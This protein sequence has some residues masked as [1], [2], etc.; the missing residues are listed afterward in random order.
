MS[1]KDVVH[2]G[3]LAHL[4]KGLV[5]LKKKR[6]KYFL[7]VASAAV[8]LFAVNAILEIVARVQESEYLVSRLTALEMETRDTGAVFDPRTK[9][10]VVRDLRSAGHDIYPSLYTHDILENQ[11]FEEKVSGRILVPLGFK[12][13]TAFVFCNELGRHSIWKSDRY[14][15]YNEDEAYWGASKSSERTAV[16]IGDSMVAGACVEQGEDIASR[17]RE[18]NIRAISLGIPGAGPIR[19]LA[20]FREYALPLQP[21]V[22]VWFFSE[23]ND[24]VDA[25]TESRD[26]FLRQYLKP[27]FRQDLLEKQTDI[28]RTWGEFLV[29]RMQEQEPPE[30]SAGKNFQDMLRR[31]M[32]Y[33]TL[34]Q[35]RSRLALTRGAFRDA[36][37]VELVRNI[38][39]EVKAISED[40]NIDLVLAYLP[41]REAFISKDL[42]THGHIR[43]IASS[44]NIPFISIREVFLSEG[45]PLRFFPRP[46]IFPHYRPEGYQVVAEAVV[47]HLGK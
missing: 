22:I 37:A 12:S 5:Y 40:H 30:R 1:A 45:D 16:L 18:Q 26:P 7:A 21:D 17:L 8:S 32:P 31:L 39:K 43:D 10:V 13:R 15:F 44:L 9:M 47:R 33:T 35:V 38:L 42:S 4:I 19:E 25:I 36:E 29:A 41:R 3:G 27:T 2:W 28:D 46:R 23:L 34:Y 20:T 24:L 6:K 14:G 11:T